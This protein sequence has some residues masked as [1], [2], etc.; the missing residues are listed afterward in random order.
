M[1]T[2]DRR[3]FL[4]KSMVVAPAAEGVLFARSAGAETQADTQRAEFFK[5]WDVNC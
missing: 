3:E 2:S 5:G 1:L 4:K